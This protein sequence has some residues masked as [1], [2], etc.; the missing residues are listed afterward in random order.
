MKNEMIEIERGWKDDRREDEIFDRIG[1]K[2]VRKF[3]DAFMLVSFFSFR[4]IQMC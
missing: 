4:I 3:K 1:K 2:R